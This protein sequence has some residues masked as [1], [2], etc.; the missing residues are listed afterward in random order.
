M[1]GCL[2]EEEEEE[3]EEEQRKKEI[4]IVVSLPIGSIFDHIQRAIYP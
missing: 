3:E 2:A 1:A 4:S